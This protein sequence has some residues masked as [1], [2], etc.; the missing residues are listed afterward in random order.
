MLR[1]YLTTALR[2]IRRHRVYA[3]INV[4]GLSLGLAC[5]MLIILYVKDETSYDRFHPRVNRIFRIDREL[6][7]DNGNKVQGGNSGYFQGPHFKARI[8]EIET[9]VRVQEAMVNLRRGA[10]VQA[11]YG[12]RVDPNFFSVFNFPLLSGSPASALTQ[13]HSVVIT[14]DLALAQFGTK[15]AVGKTIEIQGDDGFVPYLVTGVARNCPQNSSIKFQLLLPLAEPAEAE[16]HVENWFNFFL[17]TFVVVSPGADIR[18][19]DQKMQRVFETDGGDAI[20]LIQQKYQIHNIGMS[21]FLQPMTDIHLSVKA[22][23]DEGLSDASDPVYSYVLSGIALFILLIAC[24][25]FINL[26]VA[27]SLKRAREIGVRKVIGGQ[28]RQLVL[29]FMGESFLLCLG[30]FVLA[31]LIAQ[32]LLPWFNQLSNKALSFSYLLDIRLAA[33]YVGLLLATG[34]LAGFYPALVLS[35]YQPVQTLYNR[36]TLRGKNYLQK[37]LVV[38]QFML[39]AFLIVATLTLV[40]QLNY[41]T[42]QPLGYDDSNLLT[43]YGGGNVSVFEKELLKNPAILGVAPTNDGTPGT[44]VRV[45]GGTTNINVI[46]QTVDSSFLPALRIP[47]VGGRNFSPLFPSDSTHSVLVNEAFVKEAGWANPI[48]QSVRFYEP[49]DTTYTV[50][51]VVRDYHYKPLTEKIAPQVFLMGGNNGIVYIKI[52]PHHETT[53]LPYIEKTF[54]EVFPLTPYYYDFKDQM[55]AASYEA[56]EKWK[57]MVLFGAALTIFISCIGLF[58]LSVLS[59]ERRTK[60]LG[61]RKVLGASTSRLVALLSAD[62]LRLVLVAL[63]IA[64][65]LAWVGA[66]RWLERYP[67]RISL[68]GWMFALAG[69]IVVVLAMGTISFQAVRA[70]R[71]NPVGNLRTE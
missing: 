9:F 57:Q 28:R 35:H 15:D 2:H 37:G 62:F 29:Q 25:N 58:G 53:V 47:M 22:G 33:G 10:D 54:K 1:H 66:S 44:T 8:P 14:E 50:V 49:K 6:T 52:A 27:R 70:A 56:E 42:S 36:L 38:F 63:L 68:T 46:M 4:A 12:R 41:L 31:I 5:T 65:P 55:N 19:V 20:K 17:T 18:A 67:Y 3:I 16:S 32:A 26:T 48:G 61:I 71:R 69:G 39:A 11:Q 59:A 7:R 64:L 51:G 21:Y 45:N 30:A 60:E 23:A 13:P 34:L 43:V 40:S 24:I